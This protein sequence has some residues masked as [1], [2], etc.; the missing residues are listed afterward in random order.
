MQCEGCNRWCCERV[1]CKRCNTGPFCFHRCFKHHAEYC[2]DYGPKADE[3]WT[4][5]VKN[6]M[7]K[8]VSIYDQYEKNTNSKKDGFKEVTAAVKNGVPTLRRKPSR[9]PHHHQVVNHGSKGT[10]GNIKYSEDDEICQNDLRAAPA[11]EF[12]VFCSEQMIRSKIK[13]E[14][15]QDNSKPT[16]YR[17]NKTSKSNVSRLIYLC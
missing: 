2:R 17:S 1:H 8:Q 9:N 6:G 13:V 12:S 14:R 10:R 11:E 16:Q 15:W 4:D 3:L 5:F 7:W